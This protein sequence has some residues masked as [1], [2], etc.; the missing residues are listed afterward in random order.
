MGKI[1]VSNFMRL[2]VFLIAILLPAALLADE[3]TIKKGDTLWDISEEKMQDPFLWPELWKANPHIKNPHCIY[4]G[5][6]LNL[7]DKAEKQK[8]EE[9]K[10]EVR[11]A[12]KKAEKEII[13]AKIT[14]KKIPV[15]KGSYLAPRE[16]LLQGGYITDE[17]KS[18]G[19]II[20][21]PQR[22][23]LMGRGDYVYIE[24]DKPANIN[25]KFYIVSRPEMVIH[26][27]TKDD[28]GYLIRVNGV[29]EVTGE[30]NGNKKALIIE[31]FTEIIKEDILIAFYP[32]ELPVPVKPDK[33]RRPSVS[34]T[35]IRLWDKYNISGAGS[36]VYLDRG[37]SDGIEIGDVFEI[38]SSEKPNIPLGTAQVISIKDKTSV[39]LL[40]KTIS[41]IK[42]GYLFRL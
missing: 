13:P 7:P 32:V 14:P 35:I 36:I 25:D 19:K 37:A 12:P 26:P 33:E 20:G 4:P 18:I 34:G 8:K 6:K 23:T 27:V 22:K 30:D 28:I 10:E 3:Y 9:I 41:E 11:I 5:Q 29:L 24:T 21:T 39:A 16:V 1:S 38:I 15:Q 17:V 2:A 40:K 31:S 42:G